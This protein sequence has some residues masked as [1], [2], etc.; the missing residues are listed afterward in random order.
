PS[1]T[2]QANER[3]EICPFA[4]CDGTGLI[5]T[6]SNTV[7]ECRCRLKTRERA[8][9]QRLFEIAKV[10]VMY[11]ETT[12]ENFDHT[13]QPNAYRAAERFVTDWEQ[14]STTG[15]WL[16]MIGSYGT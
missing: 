15:E 2:S 10:P 8:M 5:W 4:E 3:V 9:M 14:V 6:D 13:L 12:L 1:F 16:V 7:R 11:R